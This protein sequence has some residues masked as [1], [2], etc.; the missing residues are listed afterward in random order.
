MSKQRKSKKNV[1]RESKARLSKTRA[2]GNSPSISFKQLAPILGGILL[3]ALLAY[4]PAFNCEFV[5]WDDDEYVTKNLLIQNLS[6]ENVKQMFTGFNVSNY[7]PLTMLSYAL[8]YKAGGLSPFGYHLINV[9]LHLLNIGL[10]FWLAYLLSGKKVVAGAFVAFFFGLHPMHVES[11]AWVSERKDVLYACFM[12]LS[13][14]AYL[15]YMDSRKLGLYLAAFVLFVLSCMSKPAA[16]IL[17]L[18]LL[19]LDWWQARLSFP[20]L[21]IKVL[22]EKIPFFAV[23]ALFGYLTILAQQVTAIP[24]EQYPLWQKTLFASYG[25][26]MYLVKFFVPYGMSTFYPYPIQNMSESIPALYYAMPI[27]ALGL[28][29]LAF[30]LHKKDRSVGLGFWFYLINLLLVLQLITVGSTII[31]ER[32]TYVPYVGLLFP[33]GMVLDRLWKDGNKN[34]KNWGKMAMGLTAVVALAFTIITFQR[35]KVWKNSETLWTDVIKKYPKQ[36]PVAYNNRGIYYRE[37]GDLKKALADYDNA[38]AA[39]PTYDL[40]YN[41]R[42]RIN[43]DLKK[44]ELALADFTKAIAL[45]PDNHTAY[46]N[47]GALHF[48]NNRYDEGFADLNKA[49]ELNPRHINAFLNRALG[50]TFVSNHEMAVKDFSSYLKL[51][52]KHDGIWNSRA[53]SYQTLDKHAEALNDLNRAIQLNPQMGLYYMNRSISNKVLNNKSQALQDAM[54]A[55]QLGHKVSDEHIES[56]R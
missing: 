37:K 30:W 11:V 26:V 32:Y 48:R 52:P 40:A 27:A 41:S 28:A 8:N 25:F 13:L 39:D 15:K 50:Y 18:L 43:F 46:T 29:A 34:D 38:I 36:V 21:D 7:H 54:K 20:K 10:V 6:G 35:C 44:D 45:K 23:A 3:V 14:I 22:A 53:I 33:L 2:K 51:D 49:I 16:V 1:K 5:N 31:S 55:R 24:V 19:L 17:P 9:L 42:A 12:F 56:L 4:L 47:R